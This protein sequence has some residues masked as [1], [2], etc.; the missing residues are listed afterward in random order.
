MVSRALIKTND[1]FYVLWSKFLTWFGDIMVATQPPAVIA[2]DIR[3]LLSVIKPGDLILRRYTY[4]VDGYFIKKRKYSHTGIVINNKQMVHSIA[5]GVSYVDPIDFVKDC[6]GFVVLRP[7]YT[8]TQLAITIAKAHSI[9]GTP[10]DFMFKDGERTLYC[11]EAVNCCLMKSGIG[12]EPKRR[13]C[14][15]VYKTVVIDEDFLD[16]FLTIYET[17]SKSLYDGGIKYRDIK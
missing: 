12:V 7:N 15:F 3:N 2:K 6:D 13:L 8:E 1:F 17:D 10:Y 11:H 4:Y 9:I 14:G 5:E 16:A